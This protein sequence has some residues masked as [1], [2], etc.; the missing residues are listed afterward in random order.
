MTRSS[1]TTG[2]STDVVRGTVVLDTSVPV[3]PD[4]VE[5]GEHAGAITVASAISVGEPASGVDPGTD[6]RRLDLRIAATAAAA[7]SPLLACDPDDLL[8]LDRLV[9][10]VPVERRPRRTSP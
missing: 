10:V 2:S 3:D 4:V 6:R 7:R 5:M 1:V 8:G 9:E